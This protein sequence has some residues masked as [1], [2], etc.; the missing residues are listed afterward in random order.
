M[1]KVFAFHSK[2]PSADKHH[3]DDKCQEGNDIEQQD[4]APGT[5]NLPL[6]PHCAGA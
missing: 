3:N 2:L 1:A 5:G 4:R 6:C